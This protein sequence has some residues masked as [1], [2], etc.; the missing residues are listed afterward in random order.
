MH[1]NILKRLAAFLLLL[2]TF[3]VGRSQVLL[4]ENFNSGLPASWTIVDGGNTTATW[5]RTSSGYNGQYLNGSEFMF[6]NSDAAGNIPAVWM[7]E[8][9]R[10]PTINT[11]G[12]P[13]LML[14]FDHYFNYVG[15][16]DSAHVEVFD[17]SIWNR[18]V[19]YSASTGSFNN[20][21]HVQLN[22]SNFSNS[23]F[24]FRFVYD[25]DSTW[26]WFWA[27]DNVMLIAPSNLDAGVANWISPASNGRVLTS[28]ELS[29]TETISVNIQNFGTDT[30]SNIPI[31]FQ[32]DM[33]PIQGPEILAGPLFPSQSAAFTFIATA[34]LSALGTHSLRAWTDFPSDA[35]SGNDTLEYSIS[36]LDNPP[37]AFPHCIDFE[38]LRDTTLQHATVGVPGLEEMDFYTSVIG[39]GRMRTQA[40]LGFSHSGTKAITFDRSP[41]GSPN[42]RNLATFTW[43][44]SGY[45]VNSD[46][47][48]IDFWLMEHGDEVQLGDSVWIRGCD[49]CALINVVGWNQLT[50]GT[51]GVYFHNPPFNVSNL[52]ASRGQNYSSSFQLIIGQ[53]DNFP[54]VSLTDSDG[55][56]FD[57]IC[58]TRILPINASVTDLLSPASNGTCGD[59]AT[60][61]SITVSNL[62]TDTLQNIPVEIVISGGTN[63]SFQDTIL[64]PIAP[65][66]QMSQ[67]VG[68]FNSTSGNQFLITAWTQ[69]PGDFSILDDTLEK[70][71]RIAPVL[72]A[73]NT[74]SDS[75]CI[76]GNGWVY[77]IQADP[78][79]SYEWFDS[80]VG[81]SL[82]GRGDSLAVGPLA[83]PTTYFVEPKSIVHDQMGPLSNQ[84]GTGATYTNFP[85]GLVFDAFIDFILDSVTVYPTDTGLVSVVLR[86]TGGQTLDSISVLVEPSFPNAPTRIAIGIEVP[87]G[88]DHQ[89][90]AAGSTVA[91]MYRNNIGANYPYTLAN[92]GRITGPANALAGYYYFW[93]NWAI[94]YTNCPGPRSSVTTDTTTAVPQA[95]FS[96]SANG[97]AVSFTN[98]TVHG[99]DFYWDF[100]DGATSNLANP[101]HTYTLNGS[102]LVCLIANNPCSSDTFCD[103]VSVDCL[104]FSPGFA[105]AASGLF[106]QINDTTPGVTGRIWD[107]GDGNTGVLASEFHNYA[108]DSIYHVC[109]SNWNICQDTATY[110][111]SI[112]IC[113]SL[114]ASI[115]FSQNGGAGL[116]Y[117]FSDASGGTPVSWS[118]NFGDGDSSM[119]AQPSH[120]YAGSGMFTVTLIVT[121]ICGISDTSQIT[122]GVVGIQPEDGASFSIW[123][124]PARDL[125]S[126][127]IQMA[128]AAIVEAKLLD[129]Q[130]KTLQTTLLEAKS[131]SNVF[132]LPL[133]SWAAGAYFIELKS[134]DFV[135][136]R[137]VIIQQD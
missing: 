71:V 33:G 56:T 103:T 118:W 31:Y 29:A 72:A 130:G 30:L 133:E 42:A 20:P 126:I 16:T 45:D 90:L 12:F 64:G 19:S 22:V 86:N 80:L 34:N 135:R 48:K 40:G 131:G 98:G 68:T 24:Q 116:L 113:G 110:C 123:P 26:A 5:F 38:S 69:M 134:E 53:E 67:I 73:P 91:G 129:L 77:V 9:L 17:G 75:I 111:D 35:Q 11:T 28:L 13:T 108:G 107:F 96:D 21:A 61:I 124:N 37:L 83:M 119:L 58:L 66:S 14:E 65:G 106:L 136:R 88:T 25:D 39:A 52:L 55:M 127:E 23:N 18:V 87:V 8:E 85:D 117:S 63:A 6:V 122:L 32:A 128:H 95:A 93:Y 46:V 15:L 109:L 92:V 104:P 47:F 115:G 120:V 49:T 78:S 3:S 105:Y 59:S 101:Q 112:P 41:S 97:L 51:N 2:L 74:A 10:S 4:S 102:Y 54:A 36:Q 7:H 121:N 114:S 132:R 99:A 50:G 76:G 82:L 79:L 27:I 60:A 89:L 81:G 137:L 94:R 84:F 44:L 57:D 125:L 43:N 70:W 62:G 100:G 1:I